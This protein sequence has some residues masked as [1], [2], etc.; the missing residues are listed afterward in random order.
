MFH[1][2]HSL[3]RLFVIL[4]SAQFPENTHFWNNL[5]AGVF[6]QSS[7]FRPKK[8]L[9]FHANI[10]LGFSNDY[11]RKLLL[12]PTESSTT[13]LKRWLY[14][15]WT[16]CPSPFIHI[17]SSLYAS[18]QLQLPLD[19]VLLNTTSTQE[20]AGE[21]REIPNVCFPDRFS[22]PQTVECGSCHGD[23]AT[24][25]SFGVFDVLSSAFCRFWDYIN[26]WF[27]RLVALLQPP[28]AQKTRKRERRHHPSP[29]PT[30]MTVEPSR[31][32]SEPALLAAARV[33]VE[34]AGGRKHP[35]Q[36]R[37]SNWHIPARGFGPYNETDRH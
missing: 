9:I 23:R 26:G 15:H 16:Q 25:D 7:Y 27:D 32:S 24:L 28:A 11:A 34:R 18:C 8:N 5:R 19:T 12:I 37:V 13:F 20:M 33:H 10:A 21:N 4:V 31:D 36:L 22:L 14:N 2:V 17:A 3:I 35:A 30:L 1:S 6:I 29:R